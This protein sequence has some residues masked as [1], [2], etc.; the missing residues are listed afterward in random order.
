MSCENCGNSCGGCG[1][2]GGQAL[3]LTAAELALLRLFAQAPFLPV[4]SAYDMKT[5]VYL[6]NQEWSE[7]EYS[8]AILSLA[9]K[10]LIRL[11]YD[12][13]LKNFDYE[14]YRSFPLHG[15]M[16]LTGRGQDVLEQIE[17]QGIEE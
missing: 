7:A 17:I 10:G 4:S 3:L 12:I 11:D 1:G 14:S 5:P 2:C 8:G 16:A 13:P 9:G 15:S 6:E